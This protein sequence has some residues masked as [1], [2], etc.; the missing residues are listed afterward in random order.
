MKHST[1]I[2]KE[3]VRAWLKQELDSH[4]P[5]PP[6]DRVRQMLGWGL[7]EAKRAKQRKI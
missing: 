1:T 3:A 6:P 4:R 7:V 5:P 2:S